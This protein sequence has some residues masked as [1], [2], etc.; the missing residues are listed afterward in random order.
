MKTKVDLKNYKYAEQYKRFIKEPSPCVCVSGNF[1]ITNVW[2][3]KKKGHSL[4]ALLCYCVL[5]AAQNVEEFHYII[6]E[7]GLYYYD[8]MKTNAV[9]NGK[10]GL[11][12]YADYKYF[13]NF[14]DFEK[15][16]HRANK[17]CYENC[18]HLIEDTGALISTSAIIDFP[19]TSIS[20]NRS[21]TFE[22]NFLIWGGVKKHLFKKT[23]DISLRF[24]HATIDGQRAAKFF[25]ELQNQFN[26]IKTKRIKK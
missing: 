23:L 7:D 11:L 16:Y 8:Y 22:D 26:T 25:N 19:F 13:D 24:H 14:E 20:L 4:N 21:L 2:K 15:E 6:K 3:Q 10:D 17:Y 9:I 12:Y 5:H 1:N 18:T